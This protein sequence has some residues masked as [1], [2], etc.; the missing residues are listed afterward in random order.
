MDKSTKLFFD[1]VMETHVSMTKEIEKNQRQRQDVRDDLC[2]ISDA[3]TVEALRVEW[4]KEQEAESQSGD[5]GR[6]QENSVA[7]AAEENLGLRPAT[8]ESKG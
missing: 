2:T 4:L 7:P 6:L 3:N 1:R 5:G 8:S